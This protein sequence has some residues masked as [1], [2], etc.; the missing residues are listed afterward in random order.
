MLTSDVN[1][2]ECSDRT[3]TVFCYAHVGSSLTYS[4]VVDDDGAPASLIYC[5]TL[6]VFQSVHNMVQL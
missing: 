1:K 4:H 3:H 6:N 2:C 5:G